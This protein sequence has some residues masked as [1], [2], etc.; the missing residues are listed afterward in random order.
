MSRGGA[1][2]RSA[3]LSRAE[4][5]GEYPDVG[6]AGVDVG[7]AGRAGPYP[8]PVSERAFV[9]RVVSTRARGTTGGA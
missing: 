7:V 3:L 2:R 1:G 5:G 4:G 6:F 8:V 9:R